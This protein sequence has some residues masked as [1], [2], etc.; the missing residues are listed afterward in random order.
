[1]GVDAMVLKREMIALE[2]RISQLQRG[3]G[4]SPRGHRAG[5]KGANGKMGMY[6]SGGGDAKRMLARLRWQKAL[7]MVLIRK[8]KMQKAGGRLKFALTVLA[9]KRRS[10]RAGRYSRRRMISSSER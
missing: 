10:S 2:W 5:G 9:A 6:G 4:G 1:M 8:L 3:E 7:A